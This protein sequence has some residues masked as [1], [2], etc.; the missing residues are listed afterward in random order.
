MIRVKEPSSYWWLRRRKYIAIF[1]R[2]LSSVFILSYVLLYLLILA[3][4]ESGG[5]GLVSQFATVP[6]VGLSITLL[7][8]SL[9][10]SVTWFLLLVGA[11]WHA[12]HRIR[13]VL[14]GFGLSHYRR[15]VTAASMVALALII[16][17]ALEVISSL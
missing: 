3:Q 4:L 15:G 14:Y 16:V 6:F 11:A 13:F 7:A 2:E 1:L 12:M 5:R 17:F 10:H 8:F 9:Y